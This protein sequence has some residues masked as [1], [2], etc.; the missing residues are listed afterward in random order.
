MVVYLD[1]LMTIKLSSLFLGSRYTALTALVVTLS[2]TSLGLPL[3]CA[4]MTLPQTVTS[5]RLR[6]GSSFSL[7]TLFDEN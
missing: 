5:S 6:K 3:P 4:Y 7:L 1:N 2:R